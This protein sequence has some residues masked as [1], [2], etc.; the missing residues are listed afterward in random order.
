MLP[1]VIGLQESEQTI[2]DDNLNQ[3]IIQIS[4]ILERKFKITMKNLI[5]SD[6]RQNAYYLLMSKRK[7]LIKRENYYL[8]IFIW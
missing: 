7:H 1:S 2:S 5:L 3:M 4:L 8:R 6:K